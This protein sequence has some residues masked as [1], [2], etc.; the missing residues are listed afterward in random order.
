[1]HATCPKREGTWLRFIPHR[2]RHSPIAIDLGGHSV[3]LLQLGPDRCSITAA[4]A[5]PVAPE[6]TLTPSNYLDWLEDVLPGFITDSGAT[7]RRVKVALPSA[8][9]TAQ[10]LQLDAEESAIASEVAPMH[11]PPMD[12]QPM[13]RVLQVGP[14]AMQEGQGEHT[15]FI[16]L[17][18]PRRHVF[19]L[20]ELFHRH[21]YEVLDLQTQFSASVAPFLHRQ[22]C[23][24]EQSDSPTPEATLFVDLGS[25]GV[26]ASITNGMNLVQA[27]RIATG[28][29]NPDINEDDRLDMIIDE[30]GMAL[31]HDASHFPDR[32]V[33]RIVFIGGGAHSDHACRQ[34]VERLHLPGQRGDPLAAL[35]RPIDPDS[36]LKQDAG[37]R[38]GWSAAAGLVSIPMNKEGTR[39]AA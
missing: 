18:F 38:P 4:A 37:P 26:L 35:G 13:T 9:T 1:M 10:Q 5:M 15:E 8:W 25:G 29:R 27:R 2:T 3:K 30:L 11:L 14:A 34:I 23:P 6:A 36:P 39:D 16:C 21:H 24:S 12:E 7:G 20:V 31:R 28:E 32:R 33:E 22:S 17:A 19:R